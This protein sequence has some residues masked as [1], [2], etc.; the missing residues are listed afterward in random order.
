MSRE[1]L[2]GA[3]PYPPQVAEEYRRRGVWRG[4]TYLDLWE[5]AARREPGRE[6]LVDDHRRLTWGELDELVGRLAAGLR[7]LGVGRLET[8]LLQV[9]NRAEYVLL[10]HAAQRVG[11]VPVLA[12]P[13]HGVPELE[14]VIRLTHPRAWVFPCRDGSRAFGP[15]VARLRE[16]GVLPAR[17]IAVGDGDLP[18]GAIRF[19]DL[20]AS[21]PV[22]EVH[23]P[24]PDDVAL[25]GLTGGA[26]GRSKAVPRTHDSF[27]GNVR[28]ANAGTSA[29]D[30]FLCSTPVGHT[31]A[32]QGPL[33]GWLCA[34]GRVV[35]LSSPRAPD[36]LA[37]VERER[38][39]RLGLV[40]TQL[41]DLIEDP[42][43]RHR[44]L[45]SL[46]RV[47]STGGA[48]RPE[49]A[50]R[51]RDVLGAIGCEFAGSA[52]G[53]TEGPSCGHPPGEPPE[54]LLQGVGRPDPEVESWV[55]L[56][57]AGRTLPPGEIGELAV[58]GPGVFTGYF[59]S[60]EVNARVFTPGGYYR[61]GDLGFL[62]GGN[63]MVTGRLKDVIERGGE[64]ILPQEIEE[65]L[66]GHPAV[67]AVAV[68]AMPDLRLGERAC[69]YVVPRGQARPSLEEL[70][71]HLRRLGAGPLQWPE[72]VEVVA[73]LPETPSGKLDRPALRADIARK[74]E[75]ER[76][77]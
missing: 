59:R 46:R 73:A 56:D 52:Y 22:P 1:Y 6:A 55:T 62:D 9:P 58:R 30:V 53:S 20:V 70:V 19:D 50:R 49:V 44:D 5:R 42:D 24:H 77:Q 65:L 12:V 7:D 32:N 36:I 72:R 64:P 57:P 51:A 38:V 61:T 27:L 15:V 26:T 8:I 71:A 66:L 10:F 63:V 67:V 18:P 54:R 4:E 17:L 33:G 25:I 68:V 13:R 3:V 48:L 31:M 47:V 2:E 11:A 29:E 23:R 69:A 45:S 76:A 41:A 40:P 21:R 75:A 60:P 14:A 39:T 35:L 16:S 28:R 43:L 37:A 34:G 74:V